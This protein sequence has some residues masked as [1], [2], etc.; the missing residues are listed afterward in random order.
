MASWYSIRK[1]PRYP[2]GTKHTKHTQNRTP[3]WRHCA[4]HAVGRQHSPGLYHRK[5]CYVLYLQTHS[6]CLSNTCACNW[7]A[8]LWK[9]DNYLP[10]YPC[11]LLC[12]Q[13]LYFLHMYHAC[14]C[15]SSYFLHMYHACTSASS[16]FLHMY[17][18]CTCTTYTT[19]ICHS[20]CIM[21]SV[22]NVGPAWVKISLRSPPFF[23]IFIVSE[24]SLHK[25]AADLFY[26]PTVFIL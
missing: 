7:L 15:I 21:V 20:L 26:P 2:K 25:Q 11:N 16:Y 19:T 24:W 17:N 23:Y 12:S 9:H 10:L 1:S 4:I 14:T 6:C 3:C 5:L 8:Q 18:A 22:N 13:Y